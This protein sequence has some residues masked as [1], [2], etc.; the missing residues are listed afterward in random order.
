[1]DGID[2][3]WWQLRRNRQLKRMLGEGRL[4]APYD[5]IDQFAE[6]FPLPVRGDCACFDA[7]KVEQVGNES[8]QPVRFGIDVPGEGD[9]ILLTP[10]NVIL[11]E[12]AGSRLYP[13]ERRAQ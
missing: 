8:G 5:A 9:A 3:W 6:V 4:H 12:G 2:V 1:M 7:R 13:C 11:Q 10:P